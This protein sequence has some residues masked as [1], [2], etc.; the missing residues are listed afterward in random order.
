MLPRHQPVLI[1]LSRPDNELPVS[2]ELVNARKILPDKQ[3]ARI[4]SLHMMG[5][6]VPRFIY[7]VTPKRSFVP[8]QHVLV[9]LAIWRL[10]VHQLHRHVAV[11]C[12]DQHALRLR[13]VARL[14]F[15]IYRVD[16]F[17]PWSFVGGTG[18]LKRIKGTYKGKPDPE[19][20]LIFD[21]EGE[22]ELPK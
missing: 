18:K 8:I 14:A 10:R 2:A 7:V 12:V 3:V 17:Q 21:S 16:A 13:D 20:N 1:G 5:Q 15:R 4:R 22:Y 19:G 9:G 6:G 11:S